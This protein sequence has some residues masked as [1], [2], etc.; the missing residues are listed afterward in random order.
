MGANR[1]N[2][3]DTVKKEDRSMNSPYILNEQYL[4]LKLGKF[5]I[6]FAVPGFDQ[7]CKIQICRVCGFFCPEMIIE[8]ISNRMCARNVF[9]TMSA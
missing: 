3:F 4:A 6:F 1:I 5:S 9:Q 7:Q 2:T 8:C